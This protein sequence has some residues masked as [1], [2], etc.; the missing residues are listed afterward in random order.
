MKLQLINLDPEDDHV[1]ARE[2]LSWVRRSRAVLVWP[3]RGRVLTRRL[4]LVLLQR[5]ARRQKVELGL[6]TYDPTVLQT[7]RQLG[8][9]SFESPDHLPEAGW[10]NGP[11]PSEPHRRLRRPVEELQR[12]AG[13]IPGAP[14]TLFTPSP[15]S[16]R[17]A[18]G[19]AG[20]CALAVAGSILPSAD[21]TLAPRH[22]QQS[23]AVEFIVDPEAQLPGLGGRLPAR[24]VQVRLEG[25]RRTPAS[26]S[27]R[28]PSMPALGSAILTNLTDS[29]I[30]LPAGTGLR[31]SATGVRFV[32]TEAV[33]LPAE[34]GAEA[35]VAIQAADPGSRGNLQAGA[36]DAVEGPIGF[37]VRATNPEA[38]HGGGQTASTVVAAGDRLR[39]RT[40]LMAE[41]QAQALPEI[42]AGLAPGLTLVPGSVHVAQILQ[43][44]FDFEV[45]QPTN[46]LGLFLQVEFSGLA[47]EAAQAEAAA[48]EL[49]RAELGEDQ[50]VI[51]GSV[52]MRRDPGRDTRLATGE[53]T[54]AYLA[55][56]Q[57]AE[58]VD[59]E[60]VRRAAAGAPAA[61]APELLAERFELD[62]PALVQPHPAWLPWL[63]WLD[64]RL[65]V[66]WIWEP[67]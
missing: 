8:I 45:G 29:E 59:F 56:Q 38:T 50:Q 4:D 24:E 32:T 48:A 65:A 35:E 67:A 46:S 7:A 39:L 42:A 33:A 2:K 66:R 9:P 28:L 16:R 61:S 20:L 53:Y 11:D 34:I 40:D 15:W 5:Q 52:V 37:Q 36:I 14:P 41:L 30:S 55:E 57:V 64:I 58:R 47:V 3:R 25:E 12:L 10:R 60:Q 18:A 19:L 6:V 54:L 17:L 23:L 51:P 62:R 31:A 44:Q 22:E 13:Q 27:A 26:G 49:L 63:P 1:S 43:E 21:I